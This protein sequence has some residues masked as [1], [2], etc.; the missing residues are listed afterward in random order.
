MLEGINLDVI[1]VISSSLSISGQIWRYKLDYKYIVF[2]LIRHQTFINNQ[3]LIHTAH[4]SICFVKAMCWWH[5][6]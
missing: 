6:L 3:K 5:N 4:I 2:K 1:M